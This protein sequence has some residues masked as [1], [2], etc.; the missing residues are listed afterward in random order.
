[1]IAVFFLVGKCARIGFFLSLNGTDCHFNFPKNHF[2][3]IAGCNAKDTDGFVGVKVQYMGKVL[4]SIE[5]ICLQSAAGHQHVANTAYQSLTKPLLCV[6]F[7]Q[8]FQ[9]AVALYRS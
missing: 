1:M 8:F 5:F 3:N 4:E 9:K 7:V 6:Q 2:G